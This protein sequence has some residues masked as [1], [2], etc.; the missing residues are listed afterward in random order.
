MTK[1]REDIISSPDFLTKLRTVMR[2]AAQD[3]VDAINAH[4]DPL[5]GPPELEDIVKA[6]NND[7]KPKKHEY[8][9]EEHYQTD[10]RTNLPCEQ[11]V[12]SARNLMD[13]AFN[14]LR[15][16]VR[17]EYLEQDMEETVD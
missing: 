9:R 2:K 5:P 4:L 8:N 17:I 7:L 14:Q 15:L 13:R 1:I 16:E 6:Y 10:E 11:D 12:H 3:K